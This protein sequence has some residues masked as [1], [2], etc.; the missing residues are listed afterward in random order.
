M[1]SGKLVE[2]SAASFAGLPLLPL[3]QCNIEA[4]LID[5]K[6][7]T[8]IDVFS[9]TSRAQNYPSQPGKPSPKTSPPP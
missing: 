3:H 4:A 9:L 6:G 5:T 1:Y 7:E 8:A 2:T